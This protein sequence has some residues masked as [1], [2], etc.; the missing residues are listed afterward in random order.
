MAE[1][2]ERQEMEREVHPAVR[3]PGTLWKIVKW[4]IALA[5]LAGIAIAAYVVWQRLSRVEST[6]DAQIDG[7][8]VPISS[9][10][11]G[12]VTAVMVG[13]EQFVKAGDVLLQLDQRDYQV[14]VSRAQANLAD[15]EAAQQGARNA[16]PVASISTSS[17]LERA[18]SVRADAAVAVNWAEQQ[19]GASQARLG[20]AQANVRVAQANQGKAAQDV[21]RYKVLVDK[22]EISRQTYDQSVAAAEV[23]RA[24][25]EAQQAAVAEAQQNVS[26]A[27][28]SIDQARAKLQQAEADVQGAAVGPEQVKAAEA[29]VAVAAAQIAQKKAELDQAQLNLSYTTILAPVG[30]IVGRKAVERTKHRSWTAVDV[31]REPQRYLGDRKFQRDAA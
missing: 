16:V 14:A 28:R 1:V 30:G 4:I 31:Y 2:I 21:A 24:T 15:A 22:D 17:A 19:L 5:V 13:D 29:G 20:V 7:T 3:R 26:A 18:R 8:I 12:Y 10:I 23:A 11:T 6:D 27:E 9:R 25:V